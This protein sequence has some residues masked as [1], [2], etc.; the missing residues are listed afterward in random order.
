[1]PCGHADCRVVAAIYYQPECKSHIFVSSYR[2]R[3]FWREILLEKIED[4]WTTLFS[5]WNTPEISSLGWW[6]VQNN[7]PQSF[8][9]RW[10]VLALPLHRWLKFLLTLNKAT[11]IAH[12]YFQYWNWRP[13]DAL[14]ETPTM[15]QPYY[16]EPFIGILPLLRQMFYRYFTFKTLHFYFYL[17]TNIDCSSRYFSE[18]YVYFYF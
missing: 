16:V 15:R 14:E 4:I 8:F 1:M 3:I 17:F 10:V 5:A 2:V 9:W 12:S 11:N 13:S 7:L 6:V 18:S